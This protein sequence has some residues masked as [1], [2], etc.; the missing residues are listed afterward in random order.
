LIFPPILGTAQLYHKK[1]A[2]PLR[3][4]TSQADGAGEYAV[5]SFGRVMK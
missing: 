4:E 3:V 2:A 1:Q 5:L